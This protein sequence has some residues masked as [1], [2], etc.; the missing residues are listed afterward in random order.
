M[1][2]VIGIVAALI[3]LF[4]FLCYKKAP[5]TEAIVVT[6]FGLS[7]PKVVCGKGTFVLPV[8]QRADRLNMRLLKIDVKTPE[9]G[10]KTKNGVSLWIDSVVT[11]QVYSENSTV[12]DEEVKA[13]GLKDAKAYI[14]SRQQAAISNFLGMNEQGIN[15]KVNDVLQ[16]NLREIVSDMTV[17]QILTNRKQ[18]AVSVIENARP[19]LAKMAA[20]AKEVEAQTAIAKRNNELQ[21]AKAKLKAEAD[22]AA[23]DADAAGQIQMNLRA[24][25]IKEAEADAEI[26][27]QKKMVDLAAQEAEVQQRKLDAEVRKQADAD[28]YR[29]QKEAEAKKYEAE[30][31]AEAQKFSKQQEAEGIELVGKAEAEAIRQKGLAE[32]EAMKQKA[33]AYKQYN[34]AAVAEMLIKVLPDIAKSVAQPLSSIDKVSI[35]GGDASGVSG[36]SGNVPILMAQTMQTVKEATGIDMGEIVRANSIQAKTDRNINIMTQCEQP[37]NNKEKGGAKAMERAEGGYLIHEKNL[38][39]EEVTHFRPDVTEEEKA[40]MK[41]KKAKD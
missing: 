35:I 41:G 28:L 33:E 37:E 30:R 7:K 31:A 20:N 22:K 34:D 16:G 1:V 19:D 27:K 24:K 32:A 15:D 8:L 5:P 9:T 18:M 10:V 26:A 25:E 4:G 23:A 29:R 38:N 40:I 12:L 14:M 21:L 11:I 13:S 36:V 2:Y 3:I 17:D 39:G 6:G